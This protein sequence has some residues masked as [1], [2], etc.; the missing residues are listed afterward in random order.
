MEICEGT[1]FF[2]DMRNFT[3]LCSRMAGNPDED[4]VVSSGK[5]QYEERLT[6]LVSEM[7][8]LYS[9]WRE[10]IREHVDAGHIDRYLFQVLGDGV[11]IA[12]DGPRHAQ[13]AFLAAQDMAVKVHHRLQNYSNPR[14]E[15]LGIRRRG[16]WL[17][18]GIGI[19]SG[20][21]AYVKVPDGRDEDEDHYTIL[22]TA[23]NYASRVEEANK[24]HFDT[25]ITIAQPTVDLLCV[26]AQIDPSDHRAVEDH[27]GLRYLWKHRLQGVKAIGLYIQPIANLGRS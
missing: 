23:A 3:L 18:F 22:G 1:V 25:R 8:E 12:V 13:V 15:A 7:T 11:M 19:C 27:F 10:I 26:D 20:Q 4:R 14:I 6:F 2:V 9:T 5:T 24:D 16:D 17:D 21:F